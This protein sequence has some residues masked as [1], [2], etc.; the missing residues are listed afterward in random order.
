MYRDAAD[1]L[2]LV[3]GVLPGLGQH[4]IVPVD[5]VGVVPQLPLLCVLLDGRQLL[6]LLTCTHI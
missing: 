2:G 1:V 3:S 6:I 5:V 4:A